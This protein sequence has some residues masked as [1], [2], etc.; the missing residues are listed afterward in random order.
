MLKWLIRNRINAFERTFNYDM[1][2]AREMLAADTGAV[3]AF[4]KTQAMGNYRKDVPVAAHYAAKLVGVMTED[5]GPCTQLCVTMAIRDGIDPR[6]LSAVLRSDDAALPEEVWL[7]VKFS[8]ATLAHSPDADGYR[9]AILAKWGMRALISIAFALTMA[10]VYP[11]IKYAL[12]H[13]KSCQ[14]IEVDGAPIAVVR[15]AA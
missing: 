9:D 3:M 11:T 15:G 6:V 4:Y 5:C 7:V 2:Y 10:R 12:G 8:R 13:G 14:R 1:G